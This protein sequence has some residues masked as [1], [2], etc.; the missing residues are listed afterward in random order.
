MPDVVLIIFVFATKNYF[1]IEG[2]PLPE[3]DKF[4]YE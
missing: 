1:G 2:V 4:D 3:Y